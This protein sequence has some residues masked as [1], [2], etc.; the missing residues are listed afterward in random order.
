MAGLSVVALTVGVAELSGA[1]FPVEQYMSH[2]VLPLPAV[3]LRVAVEDV[4]AVTSRPEGSTQLGRSSTV[5]SSI[6]I[7]CVVVVE[8]INLMAIKL[9]GPL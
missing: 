2:E 4:V 9:P 3:Q 5:M 6:Q 1:T 7:D 8:D